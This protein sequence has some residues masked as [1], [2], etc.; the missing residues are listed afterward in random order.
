MSRQSQGLKKEHDLAKHICRMTKGRVIPLRSGWSGNQAPPSPDLLIPFDGTLRAIELKTTSQDTMRI[1]E[2][3]IEDIKW[4]AQMM[5]EVP[6]YPYL[7]IKF[8]RWELC[9][10]KL[11]N[12]SDWEQCVQ[13]FVEDCPLNARVT[14]S[15]NLAIDKPEGGNDYWR[16]VQVID[17]DHPDAQALLTRMEEE[18]LS[19]PSVSK[20]IREHKSYFEDIGKS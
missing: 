4:W 5:T 14:S 8:N 15:G 16:S 19:Q 11:R 13:N 1:Y 3:D 18:D 6:T 12:M 2:E 9:V 7:A 10:V 20:I 17:S